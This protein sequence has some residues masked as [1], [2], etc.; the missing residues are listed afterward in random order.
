[1]RIHSDCQDIALILTTSKPSNELIFYKDTTKS[2]LQL[3]EITQKYAVYNIQNYD[4]D[5]IN[6]YRDIFSYGYRFGILPVILIHSAF[7]ENTI[8]EN[9]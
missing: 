3:T 8:D 5:R 6:Q 9:E 2:G 1:M 7:Q 4:T